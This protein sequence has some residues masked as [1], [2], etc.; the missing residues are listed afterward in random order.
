[1]IRVE[2]YAWS[3]CVCVSLFLAIMIS[4]M[5]TTNASPVLCV[6]AGLG[7]GLFVGTSTYVYLTEST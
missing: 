1:M 4:L 3:G 6:L 7:A 2:R 5:N